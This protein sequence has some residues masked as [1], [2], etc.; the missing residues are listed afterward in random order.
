MLGYGHRR[1][2]VNLVSRFD[3]YVDL[4]FSGAASCLSPADAR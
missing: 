4:L 3:G 1:L 2:W